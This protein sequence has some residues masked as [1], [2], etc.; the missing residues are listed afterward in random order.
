MKAKG[1]Q[2][3]KMKE[4]DKPK[5]LFTRDFS[6]LWSG[7]LVSNLGNSI[8][9][10]LMLLYIQKLTNSPLQVALVQAA[11]FLPVSL[12]AARGGRLAD[13]LSKRS[14]LAFSDILRGFAM[15]GLAI[16]TSRGGSGGFFIAM[17][18]SLIIGIGSAFFAPAVQAFL[19][20]LV[21]QDHLDSA[22]ALRMG[23][24]II[25]AIVGNALGGILYALIGTS[26]ILAVNGISYLLSAGGELLI[27][28]RGLPHGAEQKSSQTPAQSRGHL[29]F[30]SQKK[31]RLRL[32]K[33]ERCYAAMHVTF[34]GI[35]PALVVAMP[36]YLTQILRQS[37]M[38]LGVLVACAFAGSLL[39]YFFTINFSSLQDLSRFR[40]GFFT[41][42][43]SLLGLAA[44]PA[45]LPAVQAAASVAGNWFSLG[46]AGL[47]LLFFGASGA[48]IYLTVIGGI[49]RGTAAHRL[50][51][52][53]GI[54]ESLTAAASPLG[55]I[56]GGLMLQFGSVQPVLILLSL[57]LFG[58][59]LFSGR[60][61]K[62]GFNCG[63]NRRNAETSA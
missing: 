54:I 27:T 60:L 22:N 1:M 56:A 10:V 4:A 24:L 28:Q 36:F 29:P 47:F 7:H 44:A 6:L 19:P 42:A 50:G 55:Y 53:F 43:A 21:H 14:I 57:P 46:L 5:R 11:A 30:S 26:L 2:E 41:A 51:R 52:V 38:W 35:Y 33:G 16:L 59:V 32:T 20:Q 23:G 37:E 17:A 31:E 25:T 62:Q 12:L 40:L 49:Q 45:A 3:A 18:A 34:T 39:G 8:F 61:V 58:F 15:L 48:L 13:R 9:L 63:Q